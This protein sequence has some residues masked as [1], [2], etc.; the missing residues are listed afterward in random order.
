M[1]SEAVACCPIIA[2]M[3]TEALITG[4][5]NHRI[6]WSALRAGTSRSKQEEEQR[7]QNVLEQIC[8]QKV[9][10]MT[11]LPATPPLGDVV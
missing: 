1:T 4:V 8:V 11:P 3:S 2:P 6:D 10:T 7:L 5:L 9:I